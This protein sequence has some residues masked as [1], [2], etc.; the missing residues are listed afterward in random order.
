MRIQFQRSWQ[1]LCRLSGI[2]LGFLIVCGSW[3][4]DESAASDF[5]TSPT[6]PSFMSGLHEIE[7]DQREIEPEFLLLRQN[8]FPRDRWMMERTLADMHFER[9][10]PVG[11]DYGSCKKFFPERINWYQGQIGARCPSANQFQ[12]KGQCPSKV[13]QHKTI[14]GAP[15]VSCPI[16]FKGRPVT[17]AIHGY[18]KNRQLDPN[19][20]LGA[21]FSSYSQ[22][23]VYFA[24]FSSLPPQEN[25][26]STKNNRE[27]GKDCRKESDRVSRQPYPEGFAEWLL[28]IAS[29]AGL[30]ILGIPLVLLLNKGME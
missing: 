4:S 12:R 23:A 25:S 10:H 22:T 21:Q 16:G 7:V 8:Y 13:E 19:S 2:A 1:K 14:I 17:K 3:I 18:P 6:K 28:K 11:I 29:A 20:G 27:C 24:A 30:I 15:W 9:L 5:I 26:G